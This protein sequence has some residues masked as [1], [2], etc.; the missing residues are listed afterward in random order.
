MSKLVDVVAKLG[1]KASLKGILDY[2]SAQS[3]N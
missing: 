3:L 2:K 1:D